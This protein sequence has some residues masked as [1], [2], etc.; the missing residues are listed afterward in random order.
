MESLTAV[1]SLK[2]I[3]FQI[4]LVP[5]KLLAMKRPRKSFLS[6]GVGH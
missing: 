3:C 5:I 1:N 2:Y 4:F 6:F